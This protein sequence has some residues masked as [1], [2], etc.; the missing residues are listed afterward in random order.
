MLQE[1]FLI[2]L[3]HG[4]NDMWE[5]C[6]ALSIFAWCAMLKQ[7]AEPRR[8]P[9]SQGPQYQRRT[10]YN[11]DL[12]CSNHQIRTSTK[13]GQQL[14]ESQVKVELLKHVQIISW[15][16]YDEN[17]TWRRVHNE[18]N[19]AQLHLSTHLTWPCLMLAFADHTFA[20]YSKV[21]SS[22][23]INSKPFK[24]SE[25]RAS[26]NHDDPW[27]ALKKEDRLTVWEPID[28]QNISNVSPIYWTI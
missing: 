11:F 24:K 6:H 4:L 10:G 12:Q 18:H 13:A 9:Q 25:P 15:D 8:V 16:R 19:W 7:A 22:T 2:Y 26:Q 1:D 14:W 17:S 23:L 27:A 5:I 21:K 28:P 20:R 3:P